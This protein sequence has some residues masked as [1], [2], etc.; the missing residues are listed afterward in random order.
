MQRNPPG[1]NGNPVFVLHE[2][3]ITEAHKASPQAL[4]NALKQFGDYRKENKQLL[5]N[6]AMATQLIA[7]TK[8]LDKAIPQNGTDSDSRPATQGDIKQ[9]VNRI[10]ATIGSL[11]TSQGTPPSF[12]NIVRASASPMRTAASRPLPSAEA[13]EKDIFVPLK[14]T[15]T[16]SMFMTTPALELTGKCNAMLTWQP[17]HRHT[18]S[19]HLKAAQQQ[20]QIVI[21][22]KGTCR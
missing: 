12:A 15:S 8:L 3:G 11:P 9:V 5:I 1:D 22:E 4:V 10:L 14:N 17:Q 7:I 21:Q 19:L 18:T 20:H 2:K 16:G 6:Q 13:Q